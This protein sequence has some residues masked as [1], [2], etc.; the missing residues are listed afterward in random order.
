[1]MLEHKI[2]SVIAL[3]RGVT[4]ALLAVVALGLISPAEAVRRRD[5]E[6]PITNAPEEEPA[7]EI[8]NPPLPPYPTE[9]NWIE[10]KPNGQ[11]DNRFF[12]DGSSLKLGSDK[13][14]RFAL[15]VRSPADARTVSYAGLNCKTKQ[16][17][18]Y[19]FANPDGSWRKDEDAQW[20]RIEAKRVNNYQES[21]FKEFFCFG[22]AMSGGP[23]GS[24]KVLLRNLK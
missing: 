7:K 3:R 4:V 24:E 1:M 16:W 21:L 12:V 11:T 23:V 20:H 13:V 5:K 22:G 9:S 10:F 17:K 6:N 18:D 19:A 8:A 2:S 14:I 15:L